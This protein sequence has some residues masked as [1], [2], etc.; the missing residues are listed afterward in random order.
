M[1]VSS[2]G[3][4]VAL[5][6]VL[7][8]VVGG[9]LLVFQPFGSHIDDP[10]S[11]RCPDPEITTDATRSLPDRSE[12]DLHFV[13]EKAALSGTVYLPRASGRHAGVVWVHGAGQASRLGWGGDVLPGLVRV[14]VA[15]FSYD[16]RGVG[17]SEGK[18]C[19]GDRGHF[20]LLTADVVG[21]VGVL[22]HRPEVE[23]SHVGLV[24]ASQ[25]GWV[26]P[27]AANQAHVAFVALASA[28]AVPERTAN[29]YERLARGDKGH[30]SKEEI[31]RRLREVKNRG[32]D[33]LADL[34]RMTMP[35]LW[36]FGTADIRTPVNE[37]R[38]VLD[39]LKAK[40]NDITIVVFPDAGHG[41][42]DVPPTDP[43]AP[44]TLIEW[45]TK[46]SH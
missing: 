12:V 22:R 32:F 16:K 41:L 11:A 44:T 35:S 18:C 7:A 29:L 9:A 3:I 17:S 4:A 2:R 40:G 28:P 13:C 1:R 25:A 37:S 8:V 46:H 21:A 34:E 24:G 19:P 30:L 10:E 14:G 36:E 38:S 23:P 6:V 20:N 33:P 15:V 31:S 5:A 42:L 27:R 43:T 45:I 39:G 26:A